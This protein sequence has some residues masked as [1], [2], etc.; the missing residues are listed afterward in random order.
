VVS[1][2]LFARDCKNGMNYVGGL[3]E[4]ELIPRWITHPSGSTR[5]SF[6]AP[7][8]FEEITGQTESASASL[9]WANVYGTN[10]IA[11]IDPQSGDVV[12]W[13]HLDGLNPSSGGGQ[14]VSNGIAF[15][16]VDQSLWITGKNWKQLFRVEL[17]ELEV[18][19]DKIATKCSTIWNRGQG[20]K[21]KIQY[22]PSNPC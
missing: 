5:H 8:S 13:I 9:V 19:N 18:P 15:R 17:E 20:N 6:N 22:A 12:A 3:N 7:P 16:E 21:P 1:N 4:L 10:C 11:V 14:K 2:V